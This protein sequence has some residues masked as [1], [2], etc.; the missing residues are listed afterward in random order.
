MAAEN[1]KPLLC[2]SAQPGMEGSRVLGVVSGTP[3]SPML[4]Y[5]NER[6]DVSTELLASVAPAKP[7][8][9][10]RFAAQCEEKGC[11]HFDGVNCRLA[12]RI[13]QILPAVTEALP[14][15]L[16]RPDCRW[17]KQEGRAAC[18]RCPQVVTETYKPGED[19]RRAA[20]GDMADQGPAVT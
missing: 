3:E 1:N 20:L 18:M 16:I 15:C 4:A 17:Y 13:V 8:Q 5:L 12:T 9:V 19:Y 14:A 2:P 6:L 7:T 10:F 11:C